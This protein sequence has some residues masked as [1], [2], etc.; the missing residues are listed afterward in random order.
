MS[1]AAASGTKMEKIKIYDT[2]SGVLFSKKFHWNCRIYFVWLEF[3][4]GVRSSDRQLRA[5]GTTWCARDTNHYDAIKMCRADFVFFSNTYIGAVISGTFHHHFRFGKNLFSG[6]IDIESG[7]YSRAYSTEWN[8]FSYN[9]KWIYSAHNTLSSHSRWAV[10]LHWKY[11]AAANV[12][13]TSN[14]HGVH[15]R[16]EKENK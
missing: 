11:V 14:A 16:R 9:S 4:L 5:I 3:L 6:T 12:G 1:A 7:Q 2:G 8:T 15:G 10:C 13:K